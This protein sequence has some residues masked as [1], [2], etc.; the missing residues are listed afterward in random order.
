M[1]YLQSKGISADDLE[2]W[3]ESQAVILEAIVNVQVW[4]SDCSFPESQPQFNDD[5]YK[6]IA[7]IH[8]EFL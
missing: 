5:F 7:W 1:D 6:W 8:R 4:F 3:K 2:S